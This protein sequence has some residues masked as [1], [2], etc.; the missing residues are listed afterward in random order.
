[1]RKEYLN[2]IKNIYKYNLIYIIKNLINKTIQKFFLLKNK[3]PKRAEF[4]KGYYIKNLEQ[5]D[6][7]DN[8]AFI[9]KINNEFKTLKINQN[10]DELININ[11]YEI[12]Q[13][14][15]RFYWLNNKFDKKSINNLKILVNSW[16]LKFN[17]DTEAWQSYTSA[18][19]FFNSLPI[20]KNLYS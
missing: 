16:I 17:N 11:D 1:M 18:E 14:F 15:H 10:W 20:I 5:L 7:K 12:R 13:S 4:I 3:Y 6:S 9:F 19:D 8:P 2:F